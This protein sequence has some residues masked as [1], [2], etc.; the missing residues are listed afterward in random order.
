M[1]RFLPFAILALAASS[2]AAGCTISV[3]GPNLCLAAAGYADGVPAPSASGSSAAEVPMLRGTHPLAL[4][5]TIAA[6]AE[7]GLLVSVPEKVLARRSG[8]F[9]LGATGLL[10]FVEP[11]DDTCSDGDTSYFKARFTADDAEGAAEVVVL[12]DGAGFV[13]F[14]ISIVK[15]T[16]LDLLPPDP[17]VVG[18][19]ARICAIARS[20]TGAPL[21][22]DDSL[23]MTVTGPAMLSLFDPGGA[24]HKLTASAPG[25]ISITVTGLGLTRT[26]DLEAVGG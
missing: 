10:H 20:A 15:A 7:E 11:I 3:G 5:D 22:A 19:A 1:L 25:P 21:Y 12:D 17:V 24:C 26:I 16:T 9:G 6:G 14:P 13:S 4:P 23:S 18:K 2:S 8:S